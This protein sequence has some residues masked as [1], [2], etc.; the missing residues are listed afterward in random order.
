MQHCCMNQRPKCCWAYQ[1]TTNS[2]YDSKYINSTQ[3]KCRWWNITILLGKASYG[4]C[5][6]R[7]D[8]LDVS[9]GLVDIQIQT[10]LVKP[11]VAIVA[12]NHRSCFVID[13]PTC[14]VNMFLN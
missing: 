10:V 9:V 8:P 7:T 2:L 3:S 4:I 13:L 6:R 11:F 1:L 5:T 12:G 14:T